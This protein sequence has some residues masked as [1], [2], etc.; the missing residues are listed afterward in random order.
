[1]TTFHT[2]EKYVSQVPAMQ[3]LIAFGYTPLSQAEAEKKRGK[4]HRVL[5]E[6]VLAEQILRI[7]RFT[8]RGEE[9][10]FSAGDAEE[11]IRRLKPSP[12]EQRGLV[13]TNQDIYDALILGTT[14]EKTIDGDRKSYSLRYIDWNTPE[15]NAYHATV[16]VTVERTG[17]ALTRRCD[18]VL[19]VNGI[20]LVVIE[21][22]SPT[23]SITQAISQQIRN[24]GA[25]EIPHLFHYAQLLLATNKNEVRY[26][27]VGTSKKYW[28]NWKDEQDKDETIHALV[29]R[30]LTDTT[31]I[32][33]FSGDFAPARRFFDQMQ[34]E[35][36]RAVTEQ[37]RVLYALCRPERLLEL[38]RN[39]CVFDG[40]VKKLGR[41]QQFFGV[42]ET[43]RR[44]KQFDHEGRR[45]GGVIWHTQGSGKSLTMVMLGKALAQ[46]PDLTNARIIIATDRDDL[47]KQI[48]DTFKSCQLEPIRATSGTQL[49]ELI[50]QKKPLITTIINKFYAAGQSRAFFDNDPNVFVLVDESHRTQ[51]GKNK[52]FSGFG[53]MMRRILPKACYIGFTGTPLLKDEKST[54]DTFGG[55]IHKYTIDD[56]VR[57]GAVVPLLYEGRYIEQKLS[58]QV[59]DEWFDRVAKGLTDEQ[60]ADLKSKF[61]RMSMLA[62]TEQAIYAKAIDISEHYRQSWQG[63]G[64]KAQLVAPSKSAAI[65]FKD[66]LDDIGHVSSEVVISGPD[67]REG[68]EEVDR[69]SK[70]RVKTF[71]ADMMKKYGT[72][73]EYNRQIIESFKGS[74]DPEIL[75]V[76]SKLLTGFDAPRNTILYI[77]KQLKE[78]NLLQAIARVN[79]LFEENDQ[80]KQF[81]YIVDYEGLLGELDKALTNYSSFDGYA[82]EDLAGSVHDIREELR[83]LPVL[84]QNVWG[85]FA[86]VTN[87][88]DHEQLEQYLADDAIRDEF[89]AALREFSKCLHTALSSEKTY[90]VF[91]AK[92][93]DT[94]KADWKRF[95]N[96]KRSVQIRYQEVVDIKEYEPKIQKLLDDHII[97]TPA[98]I[99]VTEV[100]INDP[101]ALE[102]VIAEQGVTAAS[103]A[104][105]IASATKKTITERMEEDPTLYKAFSQMLEE[106]IR[107]Y[108]SKRISEKDYLKR[109]SE[110]AKDVASGKRAENIPSKIQ[111]N[112]DAQAFYGALL[113]TIKSHLPEGTSAEATAAEISLAALSII[114]KHLIVN[115]WQNPDAMKK[116]QNTLDDYFFDV[117]GPEMAV[118]LT[119]DEL[120]KV[121]ESLMAIARARFP[122]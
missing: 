61:S 29:N 18:I 106:A 121:L 79:R 56:A 99:I 110:I 68:N 116:I 76:V 43:L 92:E 96:L 83:K 109:V 114:K 34:T 85:I 14:I 91:G 41:Y 82:E 5:L 39:F 46:D 2:T 19:F 94:F 71:W 103:K 59:I 104:D 53:V 27:T 44:L 73:E 72:E 22:K 74:G 62:K 38:I 8:S 35:G 55:L 47:D 40:G 107:E 84:H 77:C 26:G 97:A 89:Y 6:D 87:K 81:G 101:S 75:I 119:P 66:I 17:S 63:T 37:D 57:D 49:I 1:M 54:L 45:R 50:Q 69:T 112:L 105:R 28:Q 117:V 86:S 33:L 108:R 21:N 113:P 4:L 118:S 95:T 122:G 12:I 67:D 90:D 10:S 15:N 32:A 93:L 48:K 31:K 80:P 98:Q 24:Q 60:K 7:N 78:H 9:H 23:E 11:A 120:D 58:G 115:I 100:N 16:E 65:R 25:D 88:L 102:A 36:T 70:D 3:A 64:R 42:R 13:R 20:P 52:G 30:P 111:D 51:T